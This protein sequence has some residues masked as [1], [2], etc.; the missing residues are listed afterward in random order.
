MTDQNK[1]F[2]AGALILILCLPCLFCPGQQFRRIAADYSVKE[3]LTDGSQNLQLGKVYYDLINKHICYQVTFPKKETIIISDTLMI[4]VY[5]SGKKEA[6]MGQGMVYFSIF[7]LLL[8]GDLPY[9]GIQKM[10]YHM[11]GVQNEDSLVISTWVVKDNV[12][13]K[14]PK[15]MIAQNNKRLYSF[16]AFDS[17]DKI[18]LKQFFENYS[19]IDGLAIPLEIISF[20]FFDEGEAINWLRLT[21]IEINNYNSNENYS[22]TISDFL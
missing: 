19:I 9:F 14:T 13:S 11:T 3:Q 6:V 16:V 18:V 20:Y 2:L 12:Q 21:D 15:I 4:S 1:K 17:K 10:P 8:Q 22:L 5:E 7:H